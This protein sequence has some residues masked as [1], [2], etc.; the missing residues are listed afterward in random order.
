M[1]KYIVLLKTFIVNSFVQPLHKS[2]FSFRSPLKNVMVLQQS[3]KYLNSLNLCCHW[4]GQVII[5]GLSKEVFFSERPVCMRSQ[6][7]GRLFNTVDNSLSGSLAPLLARVST[8]LSRAFFVL[9]GSEVVSKLDSMPALSYS[10]RQL[11]VNRN[12]QR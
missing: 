6:Q 11:D 1:H 12:R 2:I 8:R 10:G 5:G 7:V 9:L 4:I 3:V